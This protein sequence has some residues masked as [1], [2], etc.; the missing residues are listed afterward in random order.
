[1]E[2]SG[3]SK[4]IKFFAT[5][6]NQLREDSV[7]IFAHLFIIGCGFPAIAY[8]WGG[9]GRA[10]TIFGSMV[11]NDSIYKYSVV[12]IYVV[13]LLLKWVFVFNKWNRGGFFYKTLDELSNALLSIVLIISGFLLFSAMVMNDYYPF[14]WAA[15][16]IVSFCL[17]AWLAYFS[18]FTVDKFERVAKERADK[19]A[20]TRQAD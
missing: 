13:S 6:Y 14:L 4:G 9:E 20:R 11:G 3:L 12:G 2:F 16:S 19:K 15:L 7:K 8:L 5:I 10:L 1:M 17:Y 18:N